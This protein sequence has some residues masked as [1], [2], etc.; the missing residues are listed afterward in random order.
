MLSAS[1]NPAYYSHAPGDSL[2]HVLSPVCSS[3]VPEENNQR[4]AVTKFASYDFPYLAETARP[5]PLAYCVAP[6]VLSS[7]SA[8]CCVVEVAS[9]LQEE[10]NMVTRLIARNE[11]EKSRRGTTTKNSTSKKRKKYTH[12]LSRDVRLEARLGLKQ[13]T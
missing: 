2:T 7:K 1:S 9:E 6:N 13:N 8:T 12:F 10:G 4:S 3:T 11:T 5:C